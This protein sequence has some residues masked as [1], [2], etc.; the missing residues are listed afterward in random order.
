MYKYV[1]LLFKSVQQKIL[2][3]NLSQYALI[4]LKYIINSLVFKKVLLQRG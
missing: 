3:K 2:K 1:Q 4:K